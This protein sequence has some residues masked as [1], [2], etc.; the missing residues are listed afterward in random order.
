MRTKNVVA[1]YVVLVH[2]EGFAA[3]KAYEFEQDVHVV[4]LYRAP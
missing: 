2:G 1:L 4:H 3:I